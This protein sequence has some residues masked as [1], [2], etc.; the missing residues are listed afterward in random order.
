[1]A[2]D[3]TRA[4]AVIAV[5]FRRETL[6]LKRDVA[7]ARFGGRLLLNGTHTT[8]IKEAGVGD[9][10]TL[11]G[12]TGCRA[13]TAAGREGDEPPGDAAASAG[14]AGSGGPGE[15]TAISRRERGQPHGRGRR[16]EP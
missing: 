3:E 13:R 8:P 10:T 7:K 1:V 16:P 15:R 12:G 4:P 9:Y 5:T 11:S 6:R 14:G 2:A